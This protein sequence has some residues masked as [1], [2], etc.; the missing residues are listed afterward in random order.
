MSMATVS[1]STSSNGTRPIPRTSPRR[2]YT[3]DVYIDTYR[4]DGT[5]LHRVDLGVNIRE[6]AH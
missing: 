5:L 1:T 3:G 6:G 4:L 2:G